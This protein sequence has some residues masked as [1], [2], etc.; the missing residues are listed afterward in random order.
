MRGLPGEPS[1]QEVFICTWV[2]RAALET[3]SG[4]Q[5]WA[6]W[7]IKPQA[8]M[9]WLV[10]EQGSGVS[11]PGLLGVGKASPPLNGKMQAT[12]QSAPCKEGGLS[13]LVRK[14]VPSTRLGI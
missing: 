2:P 1:A 6:W 5:A 7:K 12:H 14:N 4:K 3:C 11:H 8:L 9:R 10:K 13:F